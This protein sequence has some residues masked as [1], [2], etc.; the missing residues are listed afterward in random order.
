MTRSI[1]AE[2][3]LESAYLHHFQNIYFAS[4]PVISKKFKLVP[5]SMLEFDITI[6]T[7]S[8]IS[9]EG[10]M[11]TYIKLS[12]TPYNTEKIRPK[13]DP[14]HIL[15]VCYRYGACAMGDFHL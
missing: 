12:V 9:S 6:F 11:T 14:Q 3:Q 5:K 2:F 15:R 13:Q 8:T 1:Q 4:M 10:T 7:Q